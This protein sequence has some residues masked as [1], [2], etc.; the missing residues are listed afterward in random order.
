[1]FVDFSLKYNIKCFLLGQ[2][3]LSS[4]SL[5]LFLEKKTN[6]RVGR[7]KKRQI[8]LNKINFDEIGSLNKIFA[9]G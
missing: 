6:A 7:T 5:A 1:V 2:N 9:A 3:T 4:V 8:F